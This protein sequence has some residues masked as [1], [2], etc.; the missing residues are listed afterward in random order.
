MMVPLP[1]GVPDAGE[2]LRLIAGETARRK[3]R[4]RPS[5]GGMRLS[6]LL[7]RVMIGLIDRQHV[8]VETADLLGPP[9]PLYLAGAKIIEVFPLLPLIG[10]VTIGV[11]A[12]SYAGR[13][14]IAVVGDGDTQAD[15]EVL[16]AAMRGELDALKAMDPAA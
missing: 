4:V 1:V 8:N 10:H 9:V 14:D 13:F 11:G 3:A 6:G 2:R 5:V 7:G 16:A 12:L 15:V